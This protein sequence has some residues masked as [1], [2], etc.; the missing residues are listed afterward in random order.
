MFEHEKK[1]RKP[2]KRSKK[3]EKRELPREKRQWISD[4]Q[5]IWQGRN[6]RIMIWVRR[7]LRDSL[8]PNTCHWQRLFN[9]VDQGPIKPDHEYFRDG[10]STSS[11]GNK[12]NQYFRKVWFYSTVI[13]Y[14]QL[15]F[16]SLLFTLF[17]FGFS[18]IF[19]SKN[20][21]NLIH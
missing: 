9:Q 2:E 16:C 21:S 7:H 10:S 8:V 13:C 15:L 20:W 11:L 14:L 18:M 12:I 6:P 3:K 4:A 1:Y 5:M 17:L 19:N